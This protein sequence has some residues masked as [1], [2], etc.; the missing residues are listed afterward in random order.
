MA[1][2]ESKSNVG[3][4]FQFKS[5]RAALNE[6]ILL[7]SDPAL[8]APQLAAHA[9]RVPMLFNGMPVV[10]NLQQLPQLP[11]AAEVQALIE[12]CRAQTLMP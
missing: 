2:A 10:L 7:E 12:L 6:L 9:A 5:T 8:L 1:Q 3:T 4:G 11:S